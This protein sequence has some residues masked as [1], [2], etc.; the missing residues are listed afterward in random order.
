MKWQGKIGGQKHGT[1]DRDK[2]AGIV[3]QGTREQKTG[4]MATEDGGQWKGIQNRGW[5]EGARKERGT[6][7]GTKDRG[8]G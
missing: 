8:R 7:H 6:E 1:R 2:V 5:Y 4:N 3:G